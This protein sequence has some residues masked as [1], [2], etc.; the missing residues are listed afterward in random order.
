MKHTSLET[1]R[2]AAI[3]LDD[4]LINK[5]KDVGFITAIDQLGPLCGKSA[6]YYSCMKRKHKGLHIGSLT[7]LAAYISKLLHNE[8]DL[9]EA[10]ALRQA[11]KAVNET[12]T[13]KCA[14][15]EQELYM[16]QHNIKWVQQMLKDRLLED[17]T[18]ASG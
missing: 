1:I 11:L 5:L 10:I 14:L 15:R 12:I 8:G 13:A 17:Q 7:F 3:N 16:Q 4:E 6:S 9:R 18:H 2:Q